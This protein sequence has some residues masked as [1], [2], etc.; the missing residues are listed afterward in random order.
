M[1]A[2]HRAIRVAVG[3][4]SIPHVF[5]D[6]QLLVGAGSNNKFALI[7]SNAF[8]D[9]N[10]MWTIPPGGSAP[11]SAQ[12][13]FQPGSRR[14][15]IVIMPHERNSS[16]SS[17]QLEM[18]REDRGENKAENNG[19]PQVLSTSIRTPLEIDTDTTKLR[20]QL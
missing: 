13:P 14:P 20:L 15:N 2:V 17:S 19:P 10:P 9:V 16:I 7:Y 8:E 12:C 18:Q 5:L 11:L 3:S 6:L 4:S 1:Y